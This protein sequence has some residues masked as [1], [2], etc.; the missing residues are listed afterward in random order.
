MCVCVRISVCISVRTHARVLGGGTV[1][2]VGARGRGIEAHSL[3]ESNCTLDWVTACDDLSFI[4]E[5]HGLQL[6]IYPADINCC[7]SESDT[8][9]SLCHYFTCHY[10]TKV[11]LHYSTVSIYNWNIYLNP[12]RALFLSED[13]IERKRRTF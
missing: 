5:G 1:V 12:H 10:L 13:K 2:P 7:F 6:E 4:S 9:F 11:D 3:K 8:G